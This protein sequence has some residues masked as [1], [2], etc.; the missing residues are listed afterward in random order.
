M[1]PSLK[2]NGVPDG[3]NPSVSVVMS[4]FNGERYLRESIESILAQTFGDFEFIIINDGSTDR[5]GDILLHYQKIDCRVTVHHQPN[6]G[7]IAA[8]NT[9]CGLARGRY[10]A[11]MDADDIALPDRLER[12]IDYLEHNPQVALLG[13]WVNIIDDQGRLLSTLQFPTDDEQITEWLSE[14]HRVPFSHPTLVIGTD[15]F[16]VVNGFRSAFV[17]AEDYDLVIRIAERFQVANLAG[18]VLN[19]R[20]HSRSVSIKNIRQQVISILGAWAAASIRRAGGLDPTDGVEAVNREL[21]RSMGVSDVI[22]ENALMEVYQYW[23]DVMLQAS[24]KAAALRVMREALESQS[25]KH[26]NRS[27][28]ANMWL[29]AAGICSEQ[30]TYWRGMFCVVRALAVRPI[31]AGRPVKRIFTR[32]ARLTKNGGTTV[33]VRD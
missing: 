17:A 25:W 23:I 24:D 31:I 12:Q 27:V 5:T 4:V 7:L 33:A 6:K 28:V 16:R 14:L 8:L 29:D 13:S 9:G 15:A 21:L 1:D 32:V 18:P 10:I 30:G 3:M 26:V 2:P 19:M 11:R 20:R 22:Y